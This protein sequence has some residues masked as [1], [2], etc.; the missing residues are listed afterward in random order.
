LLT[1]NTAENYVEAFWVDLVVHNPFDS[2]VT[3]SDLTVVVAGP[4]DSPDWTPDLVDVEVLDEI[5]L[6]PRETRTVGIGKL[7]NAHVL[8][9]H[10]KIPLSILA[11][12]PMTLQITDV[13]YSF[14]SLLPAKESLVMRGRRL[15]DTP[16]QRQNK[17]YA[18]DVVVK[19][20]VE[21]AAQRLS[22][23]FFDDNRLVLYHGERKQMRI[24]LSNVGTQA[25][26]DIWLVSGLEDEFWVEESGD[27][28]AGAHQSPFSPLRCLTLH[29][30]NLD[31]CLGDLYFQQF[32][33]T[34]NTVQN[35]LFF[36]R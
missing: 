10:S 19:V 5:V 4:A 7:D 18:P 12:R 13:S 32:S 16:S 31:A 15:Q 11:K 30:R 26:G 17:V 22:A 2:E 9:S 14:L 6:D 1:S 36:H 25:I 23:E 35:S 21:D 29:S 8:S 20:E 3:L 33:A 27:Q 28:G 24:W 34:P